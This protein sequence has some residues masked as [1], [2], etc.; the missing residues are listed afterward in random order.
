MTEPEYIITFMSMIRS[1]ANNLI[2][3]EFKKNN[4][5]GL[6]PSHASILNLLYKTDGKLRMVD[7]AEKIGR[8]KSTLT[9]LINKL[10]KLKYVKRLRSRSDS[11]IT[12]I[13]LTQKAID[14]KPT[15]VRI[16]DLM[17]ETAFKNF[18]QK[19]QKLLMDKLSKLYSN[20]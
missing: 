10:S 7:I 9:V 13:A 20:Y 14:L 17:I 2:L 1:K 5:I 12:Y 11:R 4:I 15:F 19:E 16:A 8:D 6:A 3:S 18:D